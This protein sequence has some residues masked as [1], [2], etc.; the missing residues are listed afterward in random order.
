MSEEEEESSTQ[1]CNAQAFERQTFFFTKR[2]WWG[3]T[4]IPSLLG[5]RK[6]WKQTKFRGKAGAVAGKKPKK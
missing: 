6:K 4:F 5:I 2:N 1:L 3:V